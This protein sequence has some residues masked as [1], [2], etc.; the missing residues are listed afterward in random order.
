MNDYGTIV[1][2]GTGTTREPFV[3]IAHPLAFRA[4]VMEELAHLT[5]S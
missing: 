3:G 4:A 1:V 5:A 2:S